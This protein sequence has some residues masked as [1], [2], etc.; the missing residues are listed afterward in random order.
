MKILDLL[1]LL[2][3]V[4]SP[5][6]NEGI[7]KYNAI[8]VLRIVQQNYSDS[9]NVSSSSFK[10]QISKKSSKEYCVNQAKRTHK[11]YGFFLSIF[12][13]KNTKKKY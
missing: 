11:S 1:T 3:C 12:A 5:Y 9:L 7:F 13:F 6:D 10:T 8:R 4:K 2:I